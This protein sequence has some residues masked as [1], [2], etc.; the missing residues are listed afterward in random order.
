[1][2]FE[3]Y[4]GGAP[5]PGRDLSDPHGEDHFDAHGRCVLEVRVGSASRFYL[6]Y[7][8][9]AWM[10]GPKPSAEQCLGD[11]AGI[12]DHLM[13]MTGHCSD[14]DGRGTLTRSAP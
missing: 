12:A 1:M 11:R 5:V 7:V 4:R 13:I 9:G 2:E 3:V 10:Q 14:P 6:H 8:S